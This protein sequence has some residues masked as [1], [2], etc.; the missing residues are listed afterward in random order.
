M[1]VP[2]IRLRAGLAA[3]PLLLAAGCGGGEARPEPRVEGG[4][5]DRPR[6]V[7]PGEPGG[8]LTVRTLRPGQGPVVRQGDFVVAHYAAHVW[9]GGE[10]RELASTFATG[11]PAALKAGTLVPGLNR[12]VTGQRVG[13]RVL[14]AVPPRDAYGPNP[15]KGLGPDEETVYVVDILDR[16]D[17]EQA[18][19]GE[20]T[21]ESVPGVQ[22]VSRPG[23]RPWF[24]PAKGAKPP[25]RTVARTLI[26][27]RG[28]AVAK[29]AT[30]AVHYEGRLWRDGDS[31]DATWTR[32]GGPR[33]ALV[34]IGSGKALPA[35][36]RHLEGA[37]VGSRIALVVPPE[38]G[39]GK[40]GLP[41]QGVRP[42][43][44]MIFLVDVL[45]AY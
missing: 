36:D 31:F 35:W 2:V 26:R 21:R 8:A 42:T 32:D 23:A 37:R 6:I 7:F 24:R 33:P 28:P 25:R 19:Q 13:S 16:R 12:A 44:T 20:V 4:F 43:D 15:P 45:A 22:I 17:P 3:V 9:D 14:A 34:P 10:N 39:Y 29:G 18:A 40:A 41:G 38:D 30:V 5:G 27:G 11:S 1:R